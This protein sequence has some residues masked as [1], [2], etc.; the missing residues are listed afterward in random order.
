VITPLAVACLWAALAYRS[1]TV[2]YWP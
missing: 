2:T 1:P